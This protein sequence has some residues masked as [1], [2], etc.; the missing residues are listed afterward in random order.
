[1]AVLAVQLRVY[2]VE[3][4]LQHVQLATAAMVTAAQDLQAA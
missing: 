1:V 2:K 4:H 3:Q